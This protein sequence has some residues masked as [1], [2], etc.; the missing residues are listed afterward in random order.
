MR[1]LP[2]VYGAICYAAFL[3]TFLHAIGFVGN[4]IV[5]KSIDVGPIAP[6][7]LWNVPLLGIFAVQHSLM[8][9]PAFKAW[10]TR[11]VPKPIERS[12]CVLFASLALVLL[13]WQWRPLLTPV[14]EVTAPVGV[15]ALQALFWAGWAAVLISTF[16]I[17]HFE[18]FGLHQVWLNLKNAPS[19][20]PVFRTPFLYGF[21][22]HPIY[23]GFI[24]G[25]WAT[26]VMTV[27]H[28]RSQ[29]PRLDTF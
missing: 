29:S 26:P 23:L 24:I 11:I 17:N 13:F 25:F 2:A 16:L 18:L 3:G 19:P 15:I 21:V 12:T 6:L 10:W 8:A 4:L 1:V 22:R 14:W 20:N 5:P 7:G 27:G 9:R 28:L